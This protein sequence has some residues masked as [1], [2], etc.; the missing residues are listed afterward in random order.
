M[1][2]MRVKNC[3]RCKQIKPVI[4]FNRN[5]S[6]KDGLQCYCKMCQ[7]AGTLNWK[8]RN[9]QPNRGRDPYADPEE[10]KMVSEIIEEARSEMVD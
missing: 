7:T 2:T 3:P 5:V 8:E 1:K 10:K 4:E 6:S 9:R